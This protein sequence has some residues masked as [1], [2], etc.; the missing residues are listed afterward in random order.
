MNLRKTCGVGFALVILCFGT[1]ASANPHTPKTPN[2]EWTLADTISSALDYSPS[3]RREEEAVQAAKEDVRQ[4]QAGH[5]PRVEVE[6]STGAST[7]P[8]SRYE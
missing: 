7:L 6:A 4:A 5:L 2:R 1:P 8:V 3:V